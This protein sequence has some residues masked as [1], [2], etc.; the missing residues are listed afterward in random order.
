M[1]AGEPPTLLAGGVMR[2]RQ[3]PVIR[4][5]SAITNRWAG[6]PGRDFVS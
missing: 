1:V 2:H 5:L 6:I 3:I 4:Q